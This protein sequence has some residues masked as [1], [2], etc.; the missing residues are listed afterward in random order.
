MLNRT[1]LLCQLADPLDDPLPTPEH[2][3]P[4]NRGCMVG[5][6]VRPPSID[7]TIDP[8]ISGSRLQIDALLYA[9]NA[10]IDYNNRLNPLVKTPFSSS[11]STLHFLRSFQSPRTRLSTRT[12]CGISSTDF[13]CEFEDLILDAELLQPSL[14]IAHHLARSTTSWKFSRVKGSTTSTRDPLRD[15]CEINSICE[16]IKS[17]FQEE[18]QRRYVSASSQLP[19]F[20]I[21]FLFCSNEL[22][23]TRDGDVKLRTI[24]FFNLSSSAF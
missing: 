1:I 9:N 15:V 22:K 20:F 13:N 8:I 17:V 19:S 23:I 2:P 6:S 3:L 21:F 11:D 18:T 12:V 24:V 14:T 16:E 7:R 5:C 10:S 4:V